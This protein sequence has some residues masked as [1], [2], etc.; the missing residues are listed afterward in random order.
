VRRPGAKIRLEELKSAFR[1][2]WSPIRE[3][4]S[5]LVA[6][7]L[8]VA[9]ARAYRVA[10]VST[11]QFAEVIRL[12]TLLEA[13]AL[14]EA[15]A[16]GDEAWEADMLAAHH[17]LSKLE[18]RRW[19]EADAADWE[20]WHRTYHGALIR[21]CGAPILLQFC[22]QLN[23]MTD[24]YRRLFLSTHRLDR[25]VAGEHRAITEA[26]LDRDADKACR[27]MERHIQRTGKN[28]LR[29]MKL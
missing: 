6:E 16:R 8:I 24:R 15:I 13:M 9:E 11:A 1:V 14:R 19:N 21:G 2:S 27:L 4:L 20:R 23:D 25:D 29:S 7:G 22:E 3:A 26:T 10:P 28:I 5:T 17:R 18:D 12:R